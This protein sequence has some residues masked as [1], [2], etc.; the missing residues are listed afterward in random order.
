MRS[1]S[2]GQRRIEEKD[3]RRKIEHVA[4]NL[5]K[6][7]E[8]TLFFCTFWVSG[9]ARGNESADVLLVSIVQTGT[10]IAIKETGNS[11]LYRRAS[12]SDFP[13]TVASKEERGMNKTEKQKTRR[14]IET[15]SNRGDDVETKK[16]KSFSQHT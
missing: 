10:C 13:P 1:L 8:P 11:Q 15:W 9:R 16:K 4:E 7:N 14:R 2:H 6:K 5:I 3:F 12:I